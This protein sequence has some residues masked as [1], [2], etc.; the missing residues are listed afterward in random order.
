MFESAVVGVIV[1]NRRALFGDNY[2]LYFVGKVRE[3]R[4]TVDY[5][6]AGRM[7]ALHSFS[8][9]CWLKREHFFRFE[10][11]CS[12]NTLFLEIVCIKSHA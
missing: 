7:V 2:N 4:G 12:A 6:R 5:T 1:I 11:R 9:L 10:K 3:V 8:L